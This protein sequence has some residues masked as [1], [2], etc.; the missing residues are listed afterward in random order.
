MNTTVYPMPS[1]PQYKLEHQSN[2]MRASIT[3]YAPQKE[4]EKETDKELSD[5]DNT[6]N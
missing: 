3:Y 5:D 4:E 6:D 2:K 1:M